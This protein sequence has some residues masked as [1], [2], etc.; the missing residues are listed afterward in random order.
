MKPCKKLLVI[1][2]VAALVMIPG[3]SKKK[4]AKKP[5]PPPIPIGV[6]ISSEPGDGGKIMQKILSKSAKQKKVQLNFKDAHQDPIQQIQ[7]VE[8]FIKKKV[9][10]IILQPADTATG[11]EI[12]QRVAREGI[13]LIG[14]ND[15]PPDTP[16]D[17]FVTPDYVR[18][19]ELQAQFILDAQ[20]P[21]TGTASN[22]VDGKKPEV[23]ISKKLKGKKVLV[24]KV[25]GDPVSEQITAGALGKLADNPQL[26]IVTRTIPR[27][28]DVA[29]AVTGILQEQKPAAVLAPNDQLV[30]AIVE[31]LR[32][33]NRS[34]EVVTVGAGA[35]SKAIQAMSAKELD[36]EGDTRP[37]LVIQ[38][39]FQ[40]ALDLVQDGRWDFQRHITN[41][42]YD[43]P[44]KVIPVRL[45]REDN[46]FLLQERLGKPVG[47]QAQGGG[48]SK[49]S[50]SD[51][52]SSSTGSNSGGQKGSQSGSSSDTQG[53]GKGSKMKVIVKTK[54]GKTIEMEIDGEV[55][56]I[57]V[58][59]A[60][61]QE[62]T[63][64]S[65]TGS[66]G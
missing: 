22:T 66:G 38:N 29:L 45:I 51:G 14:I 49:G 46:M 9:K 18:I 60:G 3:C 41:G 27:T 4:P 62:G 19:G 10:A 25:D 33:Q 30:M 37:D 54:E 8:S 12:A 42:I 50:G 21:R 24:F 59:K 28:P 34:L 11:A 13:K 26:Q 65:K 40:A 56:K 35:G 57:Q 31:A 17:G 43:I 39:A 47:G 53:G 5:A 52:G 58:Q 16:M 55:E 63:A 20:S 44:A 36:A 32:A 64:G 61:Q 6:S 15:L 23:N 7:D 1:G 2:L 48:S